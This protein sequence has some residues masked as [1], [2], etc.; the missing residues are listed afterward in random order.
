MIFLINIK[1]FSRYVKNSNRLYNIIRSI[2]SSSKTAS[3]ITPSSSS[4]SSSS[5]PPSSSSSSTISTST[6]SST[7]TKSLSSSKTTSTSRNL[8]AQYLSNHRFWSKVIYIENDKNVSFSNL[9]NKL[10][11]IE[12]D[13]KKVE[14][15]I[16]IL[17]NK[18]LI[19]VQS[20]KLQFQHTVSL[21][22]NNL[23]TEDL[24]NSTTKSKIKC[25]LCAFAPRYVHDN[26]HN[27]L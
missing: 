24:F 26:I 27:L 3:S 22:N 7:S 6:S 23:Y 12:L 21:D 20:G 11:E 9:Q 16:I 14:I 19:P 15:G 4:S 2:P 25:F 18:T 13:M 8:P 5:L 17:D 1:N 10:D